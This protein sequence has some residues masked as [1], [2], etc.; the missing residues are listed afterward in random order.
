MITVHATSK[1]FGS[2]FIPMI[3]LRNPKGQ[4]V[5]SR[6]PQ[7]AYREFR[8]FNTAELAAQ[9]A[10]AIAVRMSKQFPDCI[11]AA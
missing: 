10:K 2:G 8:T 4:C 3:T 9:E 7:G 11:R 1:A 6:A 5:G